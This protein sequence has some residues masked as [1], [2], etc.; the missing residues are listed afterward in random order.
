MRQF[1]QQDWKFLASH[2]PVSAAP[3]WPPPL[4]QWAQDRHCVKE[5]KG[6]FLTKSPPALPTKQPSRLPRPFLP[7]PESK[8]PWCKRLHTAA[9]V[10]LGVLGSVIMKSD[11]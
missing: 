6:G 11:Q 7:K 4:G 8:A 9:S 5:K 1:G 10:C 2:F 3:L